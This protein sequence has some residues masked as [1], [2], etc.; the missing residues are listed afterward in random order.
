VR[1]DHQLPLL[2]P[3]DAA[4]VSQRS[5]GNVQG[6]P[7]ASESTRKAATLN[8]TGWVPKA[9][10]GTAC[11]AGEALA[12]GRMRCQFCGRSFT[13]ARIH[14]HVQICG[15]LRQARPSS[16]G[17]VRTQLPARVY[18]SAAART[19]FFG[20]FDRQRQCLFI[21]R[22]AAESQGVLVRCAGVARKI[23]S[24]AAATLRPWTVLE[25]NRHASGAEVKAA[26]HRLAKEW[27]PDRHAAENKAEAEARFKAIAEAYQAMLRP[28]RRGRPGARRQLALV[29]PDAWRAKHEELV[30]A[31]RSGR[32]VPSKQRPLL[33]LRGRSSQETRFECPHCGRNFGQAQA[34]RHIPKCASIVHKPKPPPRRC[35][36]VGGQPHDRPSC[37]T[38][39]AGRIFVGKEVLG[40]ELITGMSVAIE[41]LS[42]AKHL[43]GSTG[44][45][46]MFDPEAGRWHVKLKG[47]GADIAVRAENLKSTLHYRPPSMGPVKGSPLKSAPAGWASTQSHVCSDRPSSQRSP[48]QLKAGTR[49]R[50][51][52]LLGAAYLNGMQGMLHHFDEQTLRWHVELPS[53]ET[54]AVRPENMEPLGLKVNGSPTTLGPRRLSKELSGCSLP[55]V[56]GQA[57]SRH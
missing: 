39:D 24:K 12:D 55:A 43:N 17:G 25:V 36:T 11:F 23:G 57:L 33:E 35:Q 27:H 56:G 34:Q 15:G 26:Y 10:D 18:N 40:L 53:G 6:C 8:G 2:S 42:S 9:T 22:A 41:G 44:I 51:E 21:P 4:S 50:L 20:S 32:G 3:R 49:V 19:T 54:K 48:S 13:N 52:G 7:R 38:P 14:Q 46:R 5:C 1:D 47:D 28:R 31:A 37:P 16:L 45:L 29:A 30:L